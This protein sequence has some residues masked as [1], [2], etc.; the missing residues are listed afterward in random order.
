MEKSI[1][2]LIGGLVVLA[3]A[4]IFYQSFI[5]TPNELRL[6]YAT[7]G[8]VQGMNDSVTK[9]IAALEGLAPEVTRACA[10]LEEVKERL[11]RIE[12]KIQ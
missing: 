3:I 9:R 1:R 6:R 12:D 4:A 8:M 7:K 10:I 2:D 5:R 11:G